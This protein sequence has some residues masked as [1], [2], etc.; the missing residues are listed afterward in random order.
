MKLIRCFF[1]DFGDKKRSTGS[2]YLN[3]YI[4][5]SFIPRLKKKGTSKKVPTKSTK[6]FTYA[7]TNRFVFVYG[8]IYDFEQEFYRSF[9][10]LFLIKN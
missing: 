9:L 5:T 6:V 10:N 7:P 8:G 3:T 2:R 4:P 1:K